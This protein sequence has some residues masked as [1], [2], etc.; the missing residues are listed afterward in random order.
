MSEVAQRNANN[1]GQQLRLG[2]T[3]LT[4]GGLMRAES[5][6]SP[7]TSE[8]AGLPFPI[9]LQPTPKTHRS[10]SHSQG[11]RDFSQVTASHM[12]A[13]PLGLLPEEI[14]TESESELGGGLTHTTSH[15]PIG[16]F[17]RSSTTY[18]FDSVYS[19]GDEK[20]RIDDFSIGQT[21]AKYDRP[22]ESAVANLSLGM[23]DLR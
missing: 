16:S 3:N 17:M 10:L 22:I 15:P 14:D 8:N 1:A 6:P 19:A 2:S 5:T 23:S 9:P 7:S 20:D 13:H 11:Q 21:G 12:A 18:G 4:H